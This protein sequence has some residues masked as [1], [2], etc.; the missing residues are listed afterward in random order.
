MVS[1][2][3]LALTGTVLALAGVVVGVAALERHLT[4]FPE[5]AWLDGVFVIALVLCAIAPA[6]TAGNSPF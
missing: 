4:E 5:A 1:S 3:R 2:Q 6:H